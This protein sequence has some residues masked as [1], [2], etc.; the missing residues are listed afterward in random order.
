MKNIITFLTALVIFFQANAQN[1]KYIAGKIEAKN[2][3]VVAAT[4]VLLKAADSAVLKMTITEENGN[5]KFDHPGEGLYFL[6]VSAVGY[7]EI[8]S[9]NFQL[10]SDSKNLETLEMKQSD[11]ALDAVTIVKQKPL[12][13]QKIDRMVV[14]VAS[15]LTNSGSTALE[16]LEKAPGI[17]VDQDG[18][19]S[20]KG[21]SGVMI[22]IDGRPSHLSGA[23]LANLLKSMNS[24]QLEQIEIMTNPPAK[25][26]AS[27]NSGVINL[28][29]KKSKKQGFNGSATIT[30]QQGIYPRGSGALSLNYKTS[31][32]NF[33]SNFSY[34]RQ[35][36]YG[37]LDLNRQYF[38]NDGSLRAIF[39]QKAFNGGTS[40]MK[41]LKAG[42]DYN[43]SKQTTIGFV[44]T[45][46]RYKEN[47]RGDNLS[48]LKNPAGVLDSMVNSE[49]RGKESWNTGSLNLNMR[50]KLDSN[51]KEITLDLDYLNYN[52]E[53]TT[54]YKNSILEPNGTKKYDELLKGILPFD[55]NIYSARL[56][57]IHPVNEKIKIEAG[58]KTGLVDAK[59]KALYYE[60]NGNEWGIDYKRTNFFDYNE[61][62]HAGYLSYSHQLTEKLS[63][64]AGL[65]Y[66][67]TDYGGKQFGNPHSNDSS[68]TNSYGSLFPTLYL[69]YKAGEDH[70]FTINTGRR[71]SRPRYQN[72]N[73]FL[74]F[75][76]K[77]TMGQGNPYL[78]PEFSQNFE[79]SHIF[80]GKYT[81]TINY[82]I[83][84][85][86]FAETF[87]QPENGSEYSYVSISRRG[88]IGKSINAGIAFTASV[89]MGKWNNAT[90]FANYNYQHFKGV[91]NGDKLDRSAGNFA[92]NM[93]N[94]IRISPKWNAEIS[95]N[96][97]T[98]GA[99]GQIVFKQRGRMD[100][101]LSRKLGEG[102]GNIKLS[103]RDVFFTN[104]PR[105]TID[106][107]NTIGTIQNQWDSRTVSLSF[108]Y[109]FGKSKNGGQSRRNEM[110]ELNRLN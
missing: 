59:N 78:K 56:D 103:I 14:N 10:E 110:E 34:A 65:R 62:I 98:K 55:I 9:E 24:E 99:F 68:F 48:Y 54:T 15:S 21:K 74:F 33:F 50:K 106:F 18:N 19:I 70:N 7:E 31:K 94:Q 17:L 91:V 22:L 80:K 39:D 105:A 45:S 51:G 82:G 40:N 67:Y 100:L 37:T 43:L 36:R 35:N 11:D 93:N 46:N 53:G 75:I 44:V 69:S 27:G 1:P 3:P 96:Y 83:T 101:G 12:I 41:N 20:L 79:L 92:V 97:H 6:K 23:E 5:F 107:K 32:I 25:Y 47:S 102:K 76:D 42:M 90:L 95:G 58:F 60:P 71:I 26:D 81:T 89:S 29:L 109:N 16:V 77:Y 64:K 72:M 66:E 108:Q 49:Y 88:N 63:M 61:K 84:N 30:G 38:N 86:L 8:H 57:Y 87:D 13:E 73:P 85:D 4:V 2:Q 104:K 52:T 28:V